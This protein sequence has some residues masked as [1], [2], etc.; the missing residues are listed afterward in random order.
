MVEFHGPNSK[1]GAYICF[2][3]CYNVDTVHYS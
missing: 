3:Y 2:L 1:L